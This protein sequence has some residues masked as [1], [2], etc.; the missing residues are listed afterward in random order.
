LAIV[1]VG[2]LLSVEAARRHD[3]GVDDDVLLHPPGRFK[4]GLPGRIVADLGRVVPNC[5][6]DIWR[7][8][9]VHVHDL[10]FKWSRHRSR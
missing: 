3:G 1:G 7:T 6:I 2:L 4:A 10:R 5:R 9:Q 8:E